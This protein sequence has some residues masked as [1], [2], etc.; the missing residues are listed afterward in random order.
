MALDPKDCVVTVF[1]TYGPKPRHEVRIIYK[2]TGQSATAT[3]TDAY[4][5]RRLCLQL[6]EELVKNDST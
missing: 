6:L 5:G 4:I 3:A 1:S 2:P